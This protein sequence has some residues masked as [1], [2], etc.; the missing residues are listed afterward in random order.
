M[1]SSSACEQCGQ[2]S[3]DVGVNASILVSTL[4][5]PGLLGRPC[6][7]ARPRRTPWS[8]MREPGLEPGCRE[9]ADPKSTPRPTEGALSLSYG[10]MGLQPLS[11]DSIAYVT[12]H[13]T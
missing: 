3:S 11:A 6:T 2:R 7:I 8:S 4:R 1:A 12:A 5:G 13:V 9:A 10:C